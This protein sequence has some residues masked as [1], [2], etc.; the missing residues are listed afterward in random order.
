MLRSF[1]NAFQGRHRFEFVHIPGVLNPADSFS[2]GIALSASAEE[3]LP[4]SLRRVMGLI[5]SAPRAT[6]TSSLVPY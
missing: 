1:E 2:R 6:Q 3:G 4:N 5:E